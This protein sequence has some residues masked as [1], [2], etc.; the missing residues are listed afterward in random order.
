MPQHHG[1][2]MLLITRAKNKR[3]RPFA[4]QATQFIELFAMMLKLARVAASELI[5]AIDVVSEP[6]PQLGAW[7]DIAEPVIDGPLLFRHAARPKPINQ[8]ARPVARGM[9]LVGSFKLDVELRGWR[10]HRRP[11]SNP[12]QPG[13]V[14]QCYQQKDNEGPAKKFIFIFPARRRLR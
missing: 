7:R 13:D 11:A 1:V 2:V 12:L 14:R 4:S 6:P 9:R 5:P 10:D 3:E 8:D